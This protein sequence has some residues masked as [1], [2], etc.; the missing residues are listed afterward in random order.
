MSALRFCGTCRDKWITPLL[1]FTAVS[2]AVDPD[3][4]R[5]EDQ[6]QVCPCMLPF[7]ILLN[8][9]LSVFYIAAPQ[10]V[11]PLW[12]IDPATG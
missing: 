7:D 10:A 2:G 12:M 6:L 3:Q 5:T 8:V 11:W 1:D 9:S 4:E